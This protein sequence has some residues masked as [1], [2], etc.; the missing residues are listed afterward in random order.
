MIKADMIW[1]T[2]ACGMRIINLI[3]KERKQRRTMSIANGCESNHYH[4]KASPEK[5]DHIPLTISV[6]L[7]AR[8]NTYNNG[9]FAI[10]KARVKK[11]VLYDLLHK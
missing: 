9:G 4:P 6:S 10:G 2:P 11:S 7:A 5:Q 3:V 1:L 8:G